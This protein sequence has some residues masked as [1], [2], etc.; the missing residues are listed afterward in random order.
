VKFIKE[1][2]SEWHFGRVPVGNG[3]PKVRLKVLD[4]TVKPFACELLNN[5]KA[6][7]FSPITAKGKPMLKEQLRILL[8][9]LD[10]LVAFEYGRNSCQEKSRLTILFIT[11]R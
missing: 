9:T 1:R 2:F 7:H 6:K 5:I 3:K 8:F 4:L 11:Q 10:N